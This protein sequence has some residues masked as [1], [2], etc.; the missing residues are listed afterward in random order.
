MNLKKLNIQYKNKKFFKFYKK[1][2]LFILLSLYI[3]KLI[4]F[5]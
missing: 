2:I 5:C 1:R 4:S 3:N